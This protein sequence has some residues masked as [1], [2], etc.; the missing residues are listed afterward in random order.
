MHHRLYIRRSLAAAVVGLAVAVTAGGNNPQEVAHA[1]TAPPGLA[2]EVSRNLTQ[3]AGDG[4]YRAPVDPVLSPRLA[5]HA[6]E[7]APVLVWVFFTDKGIGTAASYRDGL[8][9]V[10]SRLRPRDR[11]RR[12]RLG[13]DL[14]LDFR[15]LPVYAGYVDALRDRGYA[16]RR[17]SRW[18]NAV[19]LRTPGR[20]LPE[21]AALPFVRHVQPVLVK[22][23]SDTPPPPRTQS[24]PGLLAPRSSALIDSLEQAFYG[25]S[26]AQLDQ[27]QALDLQRLGYTGAGV[28]VMMLDTGFRKDHP[29]FAK[30]QILAEYDFVNNDGDVQDGAGDP[31]NNQS[32][33][34]GTW[35][36]AG[37]F[38]PG[39]L[40]GPAFAAT[41][42]LA[43][44]E[45]TTQEVH[46][47]EDNYV[48]ALEWGDTLGVEVTSA[49]LAY[50]TFDS[51]G[52][53][54]YS[55]L[56]GD[57]AVITV[58]VDIA[59][60][61]GI[62]C[63]NAMGNSGPS[64][65]S[66]WTPADADS[67]IAVGAVDISGSIMSFSSRGPT[68]DGRIKPEVCARGS[69]TEW[70][71]ASTGGYGTASG[72]SL[73]TPLVAGMAALLKE[74]HPAWTGY[75]IRQALIGTASQSMTPDNTYG[76]GIAAGLAALTYGGAVPEPPRTTLPFYLLEP[77]NGSYVHTGDPTF[78][79]TVSAA[80]D[81]GDTATY[82]LILDDNPGFTSPDTI[83][84]GADTTYTLS[85]GLTLG[86]KRWWTVEAVGNQGYVRRNEVRTFT[87]TS[88]VA[89]IPPPREQQVLALA[90][91]R[92]NP[93]RLGATFAYE[94]PDG[95]PVVLDLI[96]VTGR[97]VRRFTGTGPGE[98]AWDGR[99][100]E[101]R[102]VPAG[103]YF[104]R[105]AAGSQS[106]T[107]KLVRL[108]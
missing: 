88:P 42:L 21:L 62:A 18:L 4:L 72:T 59:A 76:Y 68:Y 51:G 96:S 41:F 92:P 13:P 98:I 58:A 77:A 103:I 45:D 106:I 17:Q 91:V 47:E 66:L 69:G 44:T 8:D 107:R 86:S 53:Y 79:W 108:P 23:A 102:P 105:L 50:L 9:A 15:D 81:S 74:A 75:D 37:G 87:V 7:D 93:V 31:Y 25:P 40:I 64:A 32:H 54:T 49:S 100:D 14:G 10:R 73:S 26:F 89:V 27:I 97:L 38:A 33:G 35:G 30:T 28:T 22:L 52:S 60:Q 34:T 63:V 70:A 80:A 6:T 39:H 48:A 85:A 84:V 36:T 57:T 1:G 82:A 43:K 2:P 104:Y 19:S 11:A 29:A 3:A 24:S 71:V 94:A 95:T 90:H 83:A 61:K 78:T 55:D 67:V 16:I 65:G 99:D 101:G 20:R 5:R 12:E 46:A 56:D